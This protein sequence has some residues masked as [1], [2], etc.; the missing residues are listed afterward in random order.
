MKERKM[1]WPL[2]VDRPCQ[3]TNKS[4][5]SPPTSGD[6]PLQ[7]SNHPCTTASAALSPRSR[8]HPSPR[9][10][11]TIFI[12]LNLSIGLRIFGIIPHENVIF[13]NENND[14]NI[15]FE[16]EC[17]FNCDALSS[18]TSNT[19]DTISAATATATSFNFGPGGWGLG[20]LDSLGCDLSAVLPAPAIITTVGIENEIIFYVVIHYHEQHKQDKME[21][22]HHIVHHIELMEHIQLV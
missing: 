2:F 7:D 17:E 12:S 19:S 5:T 13:G 9:P 1:K 3:Q 16:C 15:L 11:Q 8:C 22:L 18:R 20:E 6:E 14:F 4:E 21:L 10:S